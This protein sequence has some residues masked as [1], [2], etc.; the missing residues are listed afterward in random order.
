M[1][2]TWW[3]AFRYLKAKRQQKFIS[4]ITWISI[5]GIVVGVMTL[6]T[7]IAVMTGFDKNLTEKIVGT[8]AHVIIVRES[9]IKNYPS[10][11][12][13][14]KK[15]AKVEA[16]SPIL[17]GP[18]LINSPYATL[19]IVLRG[20]NPKEE[21]KVTSLNRYITDGDMNF[22]GKYDKIILGQ[23]LAKRLGVR[24]G[25]KVIIIPS[26]QKTG[27]KGE[28][29]NI[30]TVEALFKSGMYEY[31]SSLAYVSL[32]RGQELFSMGSTIHALGV[33]LSNYHQANAVAQKIRER[34]GR[35]YE[36]RSWME[37]RSNLFTAL[38]MEKTVMFVVVALV[39]VVATFN[40]AS[41]LIMMVMEK[42]KDIAILKTVGASSVQVMA[43]FTA[44]GSFIGLIGTAVGVAA[45][46]K[47]A[48]SLDN[49]LKFL[50]RMLGT[51][52]FNPKIYY[53]DR[54]PVFISP[55]DITVIIL[56][57]FGLSVLA[58]LYPAWQAAR[59]NPIEALRYE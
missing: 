19:A 54:L 39:I 40:I 49:I 14:V 48:N 38:K 5:L 6:I 11:A 25:D 9:G 47:L 33:K 18:V 52:L 41:T 1:K 15:E 4:L 35:R 50:N 10:L 28:G 2:F 36:V 26:S 29:R 55:S 34:L 46:I 31:D 27:L 20:I 37:A 23:E 21:E 59:L 16:I 56:C 58:T 43:I 42:R 13:K 32:A 30:F 57:S 22:S 44:I 51:E 7:V 3:I 12:E 8:N 53:L 17:E 24:L 45:G